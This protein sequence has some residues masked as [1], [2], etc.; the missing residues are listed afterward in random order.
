[1]RVT[2]TALVT[3]EQHLS[4]GLSEV[5]LRDTEV[6]FPIEVSMYVDNK[7][8]VKLSPTVDV[9]IMNEKGSVVKSVQKKVDILLPKKSEKVEFEI[10]SSDFDPAE[11]TANINLKFNDEIHDSRAIPFSILPEGTWVPEGELRELITSATETKLGNTIKLTGIFYNTGD[12]RT[13]ARLLI[14][15]YVGG[16]LVKAIETRELTSRPKSE[17][18]FE[19]YYQPEQ[20][21]R[22]VIKGKVLYGEAETPPIVTTV[23]VGGDSILGSYAPILLILVMIIV[24]I[25]VYYLKFVKNRR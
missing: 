16:N 17:T 9:R 22:H 11:Y 18:T 1:V 5:Q 13:K 20:A 4:I 19:A 25:V 7:G 14:E 12:V 8:N 2:L 6:Y 21:G 23:D 24:I 3:G 10:D 15:T